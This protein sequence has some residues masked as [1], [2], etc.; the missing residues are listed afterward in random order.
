MLLIRL[1][2]DI[3]TMP[4]GHWID[5][6]QIV[7]ARWLICLT[8]IA[9][10]IY[11]HCWRHLEIISPGSSRAIANVEFTLH[12]YLGNN[13]AT[14]YQAYS[15]CDHMSEGHANDETGTIF[16]ISKMYYIGFCSGLQSRYFIINPLATIFESQWCRH[17]SELILHSCWWSWSMVQHCRGAESG[18]LRPMAHHTSFYLPHNNDSASYR[19]NSV[20]Y[21]MVIQKKPGTHAVIRLSPA[22]RYCSR[23]LST[24]TQNF[25]SSVRLIPLSELRRNR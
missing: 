21:N 4:W 3:R 18:D 13:A 15:E 1:D 9:R 8:D 20:S 23:V 22:S 14:I 24:L 5:I 6:E 25:S 19:N 7:A 17:P 11:Q 10:I 12:L 16:K 2:P